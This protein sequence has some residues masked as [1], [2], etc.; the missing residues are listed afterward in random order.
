M[1]FKRENLQRILQAVLLCTP[2]FL[3]CSGLEYLGVFPDWVTGIAQV[4][5]E[6]FF[7]LNAL[8]NEETGWSET[9]LVRSLLLGFTA[10]V[11][12][13]PAAYMVAPWVWPKLPDFL[14]D[15]IVLDDTYAEDPC[16]VDATLKGRLTEMSALRR[17]AGPLAGENAVWFELSGDHGVGKSRLANEWLRFLKE[18]GWDV[19]YIQPISETLSDKIAATT[20]RKQTAIVIDEF[21]RTPFGQDVLHALLSK[22]QKLRVL[23]VDQ[24]PARFRELRDPRHGELLKARCFDKMVL[25]QMSQSALQEINPKASPHVVEQ[26]H[27][28]PL[29]VVFGDNPDAAIKAR[30]DERL[31]TADETHLAYLGFAALAGP[32]QGVDGKSVFGRV[33][34]LRERARMHGTPD[35]AQLDRYIPSLRPNPLANRAVSQWIDT[36]GQGGWEDVAKAA[37]LSNSDAFRARL[38]DMA[39]D[40][41]HE[42]V[43]KARLLAPILEEVAPDALRLP[44]ISEMIGANSPAVPS[45]SADFDKLLSLHSTHLALAPEGRNLV[46]SVFKL[47]VD[48]AYIFGSET[49]FDA[50]ERWGA[51]LVSL[52]ETAPW[53]HDQEIQLRLAMAAVNAM[54]PYGAAQ[55]FED[56]ER[57]G[58][59]LVSLAETAPWQHDQEIQLR[60]AKAAFNAVGHYGAAQKFEDLERWGARLV[61]LAETAPWQ[62][63]QEIQLELANAAVNA[64]YHYGA[65]QKFEDLE[66][67][68][69]RLV[70]LAETAPWQHDQEIQLEL[71][72]AAFNAVSYYGAAQ[73]FED[74]ERWGARLVTLAETAPWQHDQEIQLEL[75]M[76]AVNAVYHYGAAQKFE[77]QERWGARLVTL[78][79][80]AP[81][82]D[83]QEIQLELAKAAVNAV[84]HYGAAQKFEDQERW[85]ARLVSLAETAPWQ[86]DQEIQLELAKAAVNAVY[87]YGAAQKFEDLE[88][89][90]ARLVTLAETAPWQDDQEIQLELANAAV[91]AVYHYGAAQKFEDLERWGARLVSLAET[92]PW[93]DDQ[94]IQL[95][96]AKAAVNAVNHYGAAQKF[97][98]QERWGARL[99]SLAETA[100]WQDDQEIQ[101]E[102]ANA[103]VNAVLST[104]GQQFTKWRTVLRE[105]AK[106]NPQ[107]FEIQREAQ[108]MRV[109]D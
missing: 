102:L 57:W 88:R 79:E 34:T 78:A 66:R 16:R 44:E 59:R 80:T 107:N 27:G 40:A 22:D 108:R 45:N 46:L 89:W 10:S 21:G 76:A 82:Q 77:D 35:L 98:D 42:L 103:A 62:H 18:K 26:A 6:T 72:K 63:D 55:K 47:F 3:I 84:N 67:W 83:D 38:I 99:V 86:D 106:R 12:S 105:C 75:A 101:L 23:V 65:A 1:V 19:G 2:L 95:E 64:V 51:R 100:P 68:G 97:E 37:A 24:L 31:K 73:K 48:A 56:L 93:Q 33:L 28:R 109:S 43:E 17:F 92:A 69:A 85:G 25:P 58:A 60:L 9:V 87:H 11:L 54:N 81:W 32:V 96:L 8:L 90:G 30:L 71:A 94:E 50:L 39:N 53:Q 29:Y 52:A 36:V 5:G 49:A 4:L 14:D 7:D 41:T 13:F 15:R 61:T 20:F 104:S 70:S 74:L 91:N